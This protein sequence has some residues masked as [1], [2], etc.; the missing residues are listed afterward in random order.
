MKGIYHFKMKQCP[1]C[2]AIN[3]DQAA[4]CYNCGIDLPDDKTEP[5]Q[6]VHTRTQP[7]SP[8]RPP[9]QPG[10][11]QPYQQP[12][13]GGA[14]ST[15]SMPARRAAYP[16]SDPRY[17]QYPPQPAQGNP[18]MGY[19]YPAQS[20]PVPPVPPPP[21]PPAAAG[22]GGGQFWRV[23]AIALV[24]ALLCICG[25]ATWILARGASNGVAGLGAQVATRAAGV[26]GGGP[27]ATRTPAP[28][29]T[30][31]EPTAWPTFTEIPVETPAP[32]ETPTLNATQASAADK[33]LSPECNS[34]LNELSSLSNQ[35]TKDPLTLLDSGW[36]DG[37]NKAMSDMKTACG[38]LESASPVPGRLGEVRQNLDQANQQFDQAQQLWN[39]AIEQRDPSKAIQA[40]QSIGQAAKYLN[41]AIAGLKNIVQ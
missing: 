32:A 27:E 38:T 35:A 24:A 30:F 13:S 10:P 20:Y 7:Y 26:F 17:G 18:G 9:A 16:A 41:D 33:L 19:P 5:T 22:A 3:S 29:A 40:A 21:E 4:V 14:A 36:R 1:N 2:A 28:E 11:A 12:P 8:Y 37:F 34:A 39:E 31:A 25:F 23:A 6:P 15:Q